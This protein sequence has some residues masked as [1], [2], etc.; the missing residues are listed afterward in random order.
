M[1]VKEQILSK[2]LWLTRDAQMADATEGELYNA[3]LRTSPQNILDLGTG[4]GIWAMEIAEYMIST[5]H[6]HMPPKKLT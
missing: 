3:P 2:R 5:L 6:R 4:T 1:F